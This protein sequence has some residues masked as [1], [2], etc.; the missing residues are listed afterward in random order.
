MKIYVG[1]LTHDVTAGELKAAFSE[2]GKVSSANVI[3]D[4]YSRKSKCY[5]FVEMPNGSEANE[6]IKAL[7]NSL[8]H[9]S[10]AELRS[11]GAPC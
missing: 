3:M 10:A 2:F 11:G 8:L 6:A 1:N 5:G 9:W 4:K 7:D